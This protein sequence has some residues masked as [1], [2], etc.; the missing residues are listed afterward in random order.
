MSPQTEPKVKID[1]S[2]KWHVVCSIFSR[3]FTSDLTSNWTRKMHAMQIVLIIVVGIIGLAILITGLVYGI[4]SLVKAIDGSKGGWR[5]VAARYGT[6]NVPAGRVSHRQ[7]VKIGAVVYKRC[8]TLGISSEGLY[9]T[10]FGQPAIVPWSDFTRLE[11]ATL[12][13]QKVPL[14]TLGEPPFATMTVPPAEFNHMRPF[15]PPGLFKKE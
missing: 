6:V 9:L 12:N 11:T 5:K 3:R 4:I 14:L 13:W 7:T 10:I 1:I 2:D 15:L 8:T